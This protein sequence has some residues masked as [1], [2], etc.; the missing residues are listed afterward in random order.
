MSY[1]DFVREVRN[2]DT[3]ERVTALV[4]ESRSGASLNE[5]DQAVLD[6][7]KTGS[8]VDIQQAIINNDGPLRESI[9]GYTNAVKLR[10]YV[11]K[12]VAAF[13]ELDVDSPAL[14]KL[15]D[16]LNARF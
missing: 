2:V 1:S 11:E 9:P 7:V 10:P 8:L 16:H 6:A 5:E 4:K 3:L 12:V 15:V 14:D 13:E